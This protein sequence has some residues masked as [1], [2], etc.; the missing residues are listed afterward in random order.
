LAIREER[1]QEVVP[2]TQGGRARACDLGIKIGR[3]SPGQWNAI[4]D[5][6]GVHVG[7]TTLI[8][9]EGKLVV[10]QWPVRTGVTI[11]QPHPGNVGADPVFAGYHVLN[12]NGEMT[13]LPW[14]EESGLLTTP[15]ALTKIIQLELCETHES[16]TG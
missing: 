1:V 12:G 14:I 4:T 6:P 9:G 5:V 3:L 10:G 2:H 16:R 11:I 15:I 13:G 7:Q 8:A